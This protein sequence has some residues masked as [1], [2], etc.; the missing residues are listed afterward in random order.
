M[1]TLGAVDVPGILEATMLI[2]FGISW[3]IAILKTLRVRKVTG[4]SVGFLT[5]VF[6]GYM[7]GIGAKFAAALARSEPVHWVASLYALNAVMVGI[8]ILLY[9]RYRPRPAAHKAG[10]G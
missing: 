1:P 8:D 9:V 4:K 5:L 2:C 7:A 3:P 6:A 10:P